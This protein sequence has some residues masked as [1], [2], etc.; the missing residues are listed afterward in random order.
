MWACE[1]TGPASVA[2]RGG[3]RIRAWRR[4]TACSPGRMPRLLLG[5]RVRNVAVVVRTEHPGWVGVSSTARRRRSAMGQRQG[6][7]VVG[8]S[9]LSL[10][11]W[12]GWPGWPA[13]G[14][15]H[16]QGGGRGFLVRVTPK[17]RT[18]DA[19]T[20]GTGD[21]GMHVEGMRVPGMRGI[22]NMRGRAGVPCFLVFLVWMWAVVTTDHT[23]DIRAIEGNQ[24]M[25]LR[26]CMRRGTSDT[27]TSDFR[28]S[29]S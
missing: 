6:Y 5:C 23:M 20:D 17:C 7:T 10:V 8:L 28:H 21:G 1:G 15:V 3:E 19:A 2:R 4:N 29:A 18:F 9:I 25:L 16:L 14:T 13:R 24:R 11:G 12:L 27:P 22:G 26:W